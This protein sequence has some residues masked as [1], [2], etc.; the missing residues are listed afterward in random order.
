MRVVGDGNNKG[1]DLPKWR[2]PN[3]AIAVYVSVKC[4]TKRRRNYTQ[5]LKTSRKGRVTGLLISSHLWG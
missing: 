3:K 4:K 2:E 5:K 1:G